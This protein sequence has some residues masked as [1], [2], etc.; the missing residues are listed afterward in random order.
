[1]RE[2]LIMIAQL[3]SMKE[4]LGIIENQLL[5]CHLYPDN[6]E[7]Q[8]ALAATCQIFIIKVMAK[9][10]DYKV[11]MEDMHKMDKLHDLFKDKEN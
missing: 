8:R 9:N 11:M 10:K 1:M 2:M 7:K 6:T 3:M 5:E 4:I